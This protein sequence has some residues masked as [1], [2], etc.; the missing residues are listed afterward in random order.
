M[1]TIGYART[2]PTERTEQDL[3][4][5]VRKLNEYGCDIIFKE[6]ITIRELHR[7]ELGRALEYL[8]PGDKLV[9]YKMD[10]LAR[11]T[12]ELHKIAKAL[13]K[14]DIGLMFIKE[15][16]DFS[17]SSGDS[18]LTMLGAIVEYERDLINER[19]REGRERAKRQGKHMGRKGKN[20]KDVKRALKLFFNREDNGL[21]VNDIMEM[22][23]IPRSTIY[24]KAKEMNMKGYDKLTD[25]QR[26]VFNQTYLKHLE[27]LGYEKRKIY[28]M[29]N[30]KK[31][32]WDNREKCIKVYFK[33][34]DWFHYFRDNTWE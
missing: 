26:R 29:Q 20:E 30:I 3:E 9:V 16:I 19:T 15:K 27:S 7:P 17:F 14:R 1:A 28:E 34:G 25:L 8:R 18:M 2:S 21:S 33:N 12:F 11:S 24:A 4:L 5:Q 6:K 22:T 13:Q 23:G 10:R 31:I 32:K